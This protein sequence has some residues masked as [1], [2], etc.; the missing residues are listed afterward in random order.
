M[1]LGSRGFR[2]K[3]LGFRGYYLDAFL[4]SP[5]ACSKFKV[6]DP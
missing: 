2:V 4:H 3:G 6:F 5:L 1:F